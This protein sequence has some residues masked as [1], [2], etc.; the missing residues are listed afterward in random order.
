MEIIS[1]K[2]SSIGPNKILSSQSRSPDLPPVPT[3]VESR[4]VEAV[5]VYGSRD[6]EEEED[7]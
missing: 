6:G 1:G 5:G 7:S 2:S 4:D 3:R